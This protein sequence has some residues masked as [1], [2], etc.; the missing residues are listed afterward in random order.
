MTRTK[1]EKA[2]AVH[3]EELRTLDRWSIKPG[4]GTPWGLAQ[5]AEKYGEG[6]VYYSTASHGGFHLDDARNASVHS[7][8]RN[9]GGW[10]E[11]D[12]EWAKIAHAFPERFT[13]FERLSTDRTLQNV[14]P[15]AYEAIHGIVLAEGQSWKK[16]R[17]AFD[18][19]HRNDWLVIAAINSG[20]E[21]GMVE[22]IA[23]IGGNRDGRCERRFLVSQTEIRDPQFCICDR[24]G[25]PPALRGPYSFATGTFRS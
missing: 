8:Y 1:D 2:A 16:D 9:S 18:E 25:A 20:S 4:A 21:H 23:S 5:I 17:R 13:A 22:C 10:Y 24:S 19:R 7:L 11:Q 12:C 6:I 3:A 15:D 14:V